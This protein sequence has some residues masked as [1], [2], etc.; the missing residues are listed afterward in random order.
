MKVFSQKKTKKPHPNLRLFWVFQKIYQV[1]VLLKTLEMLFM[2][3]DFYHSDVYYKDFEMISNQV[4]LVMT[5][6]AKSL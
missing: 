5:R 6:Y 3:L 1:N 4:T 2:F